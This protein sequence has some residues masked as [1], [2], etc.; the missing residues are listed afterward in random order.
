MAKKRK[1]PNSVRQLRKL[2]E[3]REI[4]VRVNGE[5]KKFDLFEEFHLTQANLQDRLYTEAEQYAFWR[6]LLIKARQKLRQAQY[7]YDKQVSAAEIAYR[8]Y[9][10]ENDRP[11]SE[12]EIKHRVIVDDTVQKARQRVLKAENEVDTL[13]MMVAGMDVLKSMTMMAA[14]AKK[15]RNPPD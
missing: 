2:E 8:N 14:S 5:W 12:W 10:E 3:L 6:H 7:E 11:W 15:R 9:A 1:I 13:E 4:Q